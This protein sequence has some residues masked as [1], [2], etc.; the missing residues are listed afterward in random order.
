MNAQRKP[1]ILVINGSYRD[2][3]ITDQAVGAAI[4]ALHAAGA[5][6]EIVSLREYSLEFC[7]N[8]RECT[9]QPGPAPGRCVLDDGMNELIG[10]IEAA[11][12]Y[13]LAAPTNFSS[14]T[15][16]FKRFLERL[17]PYGY[18]PWGKPYPEF[19]KQHDLHKKALVITSSAAP[20]LFCR[21][22][23]SSARQL[24]MT[25]KL[26][27]AKTVGTLFVGL[28][29]EEKHQRLPDKSAARAR[30]LARRLLA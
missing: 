5:E 14:V 27:G 19:R 11:D 23:Y 21:L 2:D 28:V 7:H 13:I 18:W 9:Q 10:R 29:A 20:S 26:I 12:G 8:C 4:E 15:A 6:T 3:G 24:R 25:A 30:V 16:V 17:I 1:M 22:L